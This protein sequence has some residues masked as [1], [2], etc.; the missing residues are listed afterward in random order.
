MKSTLTEYLR[1]ARAEDVPALMALRTEAEE[2]LSSKGTD[3][4][5]DP[6]TGAKA[7]TKWRASIDEGRA[8]VVVNDS[9][10]VL[11]TVSRGPVD[12]DFWTDEDRPESAF[13]LYKLIVARHAAGRHLGARLVDW[14]SSLAAMEGRDWVR[15]DTWRTNE[16]LHSY[17]ERLGFEHVRTESPPHRRSG[18]LAQRPVAAR[19]LPEFPLIVG[20]PPEER[21]LPIPSQFPS[22]P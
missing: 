13:H 17:Y 8:W 21:L 11:G 22:R 5:N 4:W 14:A 20:R 7:I 9:S 18:W 6:E 19:S 16:G 1:P 2:W 3:Q 10:T 12:R 15:I